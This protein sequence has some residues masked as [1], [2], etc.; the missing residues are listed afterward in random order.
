MRGLK[1]LLGFMAIAKAAVVPIERLGEKAATSTAGA[2]ADDPGTGGTF[3]DICISQNLMCYDIYSTNQQKRHICADVCAFTDCGPYATCNADPN[4]GQLGTC[5]C[6][7]GR[8]SPAGCPND[9]TVGTEPDPNCVCSVGECPDYSQ[10]GFVPSA[11]NDPCFG[12]GTCTGT[13]PNSPDSPWICVLNSP[14]TNPEPCANG[15]C[16]ESVDLNDYFCKCDAGWTGVNCDATLSQCTPNPCLNGGTCQDNPNFDGYTCNC[17]AGWGGTNCQEQN[18][19]AA[20]QPCL[21]GGICHSWSDNT[22]F[23]CQCING[24][25]GSDCGSQGS[26]ATR[27][28]SG[29]VVMLVAIFK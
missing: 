11:D 13:D 2:C 7:V 4:D 10:P 3:A 18:I 28:I 5:V 19:C 15:F 20:Q 17:Q 12:R 24:W 27:L 1:V 6:D 16:Y 23:C 26:S 22:G 14:C 25:S 9:V 21:N 29:L 8:V